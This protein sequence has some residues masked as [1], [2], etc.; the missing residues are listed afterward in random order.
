MKIS[1]A[2]NTKYLGVA[3]LPKDRDTEAEVDNVVNEDDVKNNP[4]VYFKNMPKGLPL[5]WTNRNWCVDNMSD[6]SNNWV[7]VRLALYVDMSVTNPTTGGRG[8]IRIRW[9]RAV[10][11]RSAP[12]PQKGRSRKRTGEEAAMAAQ[13]PIDSLDDLDDSIN[14]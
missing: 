6:D 12:A 4:V 1:T 7:G 9:P 10:A 11:T 8:G 5:N 3:D 2:K 13:K 14:F